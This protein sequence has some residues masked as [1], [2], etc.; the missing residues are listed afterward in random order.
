MLTY[1]TRCAYL[2]LDVLHVRLATFGILGV[3]D[4]VDEG[5]SH[6]GA[7]GCGVVDRCGCQTVSGGEVQGDAAFGADL[8]DDGDGLLE[9][10]QTVV[11]V[12]EGAC[13]FCPGGAG[14][15]D[16]DFGCKIAGERIDEN[17]E[18]FV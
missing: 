1:S 6:L 15:H 16:V 9:S 13:F 2:E 7:D 5:A 17:D 3:V 10:L 14:Q 18:F 12:F 8:L 11:S 4:V